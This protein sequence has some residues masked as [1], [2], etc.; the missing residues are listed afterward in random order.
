MVDWMVEVLTT[1]KCSD[2]TFF[3]AVNLMD[4]Y[5]KMSTKTLRATELH[6][7]GIITMFVASKYEDV[8]PLLMK[9]V[10]NKIGHNKFDIA[11]IEEREI[12]LLKTLS[13]KIGAP[14]IKEFIDRFLQEAHVSKND[15][16]YKLCMYLAKMSCHD[17]NLS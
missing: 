17:Y 16:F 4:R 2:Q 8:I 15:K 7:T 6:I 10:L 13:F 1:F 11:I 3:L 12:E 14:T 5:F 9:T